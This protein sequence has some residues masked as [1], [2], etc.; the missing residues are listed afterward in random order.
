M[1]TDLSDRVFKETQ[2]AVD[3]FGKYS[4]RELRRIKNIYIGARKRIS[5]E[6]AENWGSIVKEGTTP[7]G[8]ERLRGLQLGIDTQ[9]GV[10]NQDLN[11]IIPQMV[12]DAG[13]MGIYRG[14]VELAQLLKEFPD[15]HPTFGILNTSAIDVYSGYALQL[16]QQYTAE[17]TRQIQSALQMGLID[18]KTTGQLTTQIRQ[19]LGAEYGKP[20]VKITQRAQ[21]IARTE[22]ARAY[23]AG[24]EAYGRSTD[25]I[26]GEKWHVNPKGI[27]P[28]SQCEPLE[29]REYYYDKGESMPPLPRHPR[30]VCYS[31][32][33]Y[34][35]Q[36][37]TKEEMGRLRGMVSRLP[38]APKTYKIQVAEMAS[39][40]L[41][42][43]KKTGKEYSAFLDSSGR[44]IL[45]KS[46]GKSTIPYTLKEVEKIRDVKVKLMIHNHLN[47]SAFSLDDI[48][49]ARFAEIR[50][51]EVVGNEYVYTLKPKVAPLA[52]PEQYKLVQL[53][54]QEKVGL[55]P[56][57][58]VMFDKT[59]DVRNTWIKQSD[60]IWRNISGRLGLIYKR[61]PNV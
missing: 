13:D 43:G 37:F 22:M 46:G 12:G 51:M 38:E 7:F 8:L 59:G 53:Y 44:V 45:K 36:L 3:R 30:C 58:Q 61:R 28:C 20:A 16:S 34:S 1:A 35:K 23:S 17:L 50:E 33:L 40:T 26:I 10:L 15:L 49:F 57:Y 52:W 60:E 32:Y 56:T 24:H 4:D 14:Q 54:N 42:Q 41:R 29:G 5:G 19:F 31:T 9:L 39:R 27:W 2:R 47:G 11:N 18:Q 25:F 55:R 48:D 21:T 6:I